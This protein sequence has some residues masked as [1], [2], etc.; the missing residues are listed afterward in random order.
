MQRS[1]PPRL[2]GRGS[3]AT[4][5]ALLVT[6]TLVVTGL[7]NWGAAARTMAHLTRAQV[8]H[9]TAE[10]ARS[11]GE[12]ITAVFEL[13]KAT[14]SAHAATRD[15][16]HQDQEALQGA[17][18]EL[19]RNLQPWF[20]FDGMSLIGRD[21]RLLAIDPPSP[22]LIGTDL[23]EREYV[24]RV[25]ATGEPYVSDAFRARTGR[26]IVVVSVPVRDASGAVAG[27]LSGSLHLEK[28]NQLARLLA[29]LERDTAARYLVVDSQRLTVYASHGSDGAGTPV[30]AEALQSL[31][32]SGSR[33]AW[34]DPRGERYLGSAARVGATGWTVLSLVPLRQAFAPIWRFHRQTL[35]VSL[36][37]LALAAL[38]SW[39]LSLSLTKPLYE[40]IGALGAVARGQAGIKLPGFAVPEWDFL[41][42]AFNRMSAELDE[43]HREL[44]ERAI[45]DPLTG[46]LNRGSLEEELERQLAIARREGG[47][48]SVLMIDL[49][50]FKAY[51][52]EHGHQA[53][54]E[55]L[56]G[57]AR[58]ARENVRAVDTVGRYGGEE[59]AVILPDT[60]CTEAAAVAERLRAALAALPLRR[61]VTASIGVACFPTHGDTLRELIARADEAL[62]AAKRRGKDRVVVADFLV[63]HRSGL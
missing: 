8:E 17:V 50:D 30:P 49:D 19:R 56:Q 31:A 58:V 12:R 15:L 34:V 51:N 26:L 18:A 20:P 2:W 39:G 32:A 9:V 33:G 63:D 7:V 14:L 53:G 24:R 4:R 13:A 55:V 11:T 37:T 23:S 57:L 35:V 61:R 62:Y 29:S 40:I 59:F 52:D 48:V 60:P 41:A 46:V 21:G 54:D 1:S 42:R 16:L 45:R 43:Y 5:V 28:D 6:V 38:V 47:F 27:V 10:L 36:L 25:L 3:F 44:R 22:D